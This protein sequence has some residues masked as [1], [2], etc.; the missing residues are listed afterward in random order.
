[1]ERQQD[2]VG[3]IIVHLSKPEV[4][5]TKVYPTYGEAKEATKGKRNTYIAEVCIPYS[6]WFSKGR[7][8]A[9]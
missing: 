7:L 5:D 2:G 4:L 8:K 1:M 3:W 9:L 6:Y